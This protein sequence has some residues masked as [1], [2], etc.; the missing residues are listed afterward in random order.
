MPRTSSLQ[1]I[2]TKLERIANLARTMPGVALTTLAHHIDI[3]W[4]REAYRRT[5]KDG[6]VGVDGQT[7]RDYAANL[8]EN[9][10]ALLARVKQVEKYRAPP[11]RRVY[12][13]K[14][15][16]RKRPIGIPAFE[17][18]ILQ[19]AVAMVL[20]AIYE[21]D[22]LNCSYGFRPGRSPH[23]A[24]EA[25]WKQAM[26]MNGGWVYEA[27]IESFFDSVD[28]GR[29]QEILR[30]RVRDGVI[31]RLTGK[32]LNAGVME[33]GCVYH[34]ETGTP[35]GGVI[36]PILANIFL[37]EVIDVWFEQKVRPCLRGRAFL[38]RYCDDVVMVFELESD[39]RRVAAVMPKR[40]D[41]YGLRLHPEKTRVVRF[42][43]PRRI[44]R[45][46]RVGGDRPGTFDMLGFTLYWGRSRRDN[47]VIRRKTASSRLSR[48]LSR[49]DDW[50]RWNRHEPIRHQHWML[51][52]K[53]RGHDGY[54]GVTGNIAALS[55]FHREVG[56]RW[57][58]WLSRR[59]RK[60]KLTWEKMQ[61]TVMANFPLPPPR[62]VHSI[63]RAA[64]P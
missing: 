29:L 26:K 37:H 22:F 11:V 59:S 64:K 56:R 44:G 39:A 45:P 38:I 25:L 33:N 40:M 8:E 17:D 48:A 49:I 13:P 52:Q 12:L 2:S 60:A 57:H 23:G 9:L 53:V 63:Y 41:K 61:R 15:D 47:W 58:K 19:R 36:S 55:Q 28:H 1:S 5:R 27:D 4:L 10:Q 18:K 51:V 6:A 21:Q 32:W 54:Y 43:R 42:E 3:D 7:A 31:T 16:G 46:S 35:Q 34:P 20:E 50:C 62:I 30:Q 24:L 14:S